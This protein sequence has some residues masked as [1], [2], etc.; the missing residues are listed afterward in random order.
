[1]LVAVFFSISAVSF[2]TA[3]ENHFLSF[4][5]Y[6]S[7][8]S[9]YVW[10]GFDVLNG[11]PAFQPGATIGFGNTGIYFDYWSSYALTHRTD[12]EHFLDRF[13]EIDLTLGINKSLKELINIPISV[14]AGGI[15]YI[16]PN[17]DKDDFTWELFAGVTFDEIIFTPYVK[18]YYDFE[19]GNGLYAE[20]GGNYSVKVFKE[21]V[22][23]ASAAIG[24]NGGQY[25]TESGI[26]NIPL[27]L[28]TTFNLD[29]LAIT[30]SV[31][32]IFTPDESVNS[33][34]GEF[35]AAIKAAVSI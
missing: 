28:A 27:G 15:G 24:Y 21:Q 8:V 14:Q 16:F 9:E 2:V 29:I 23:V 17:L 5:G 22:L 7:I 6:G 10:R 25:N 31:S 32:Y 26:S 19:L 33:D 13:D 1:M 18:F 20:V 12:E 35:V 11:H 30:P 34:S 4:T 3:G